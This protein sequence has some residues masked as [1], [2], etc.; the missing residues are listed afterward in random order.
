MEQVYRRLR[1]ERLDERWTRNTVL[2]SLC[3]DLRREERRRAVE[4]LGCG[5]R[6]GEIYGET[7]ASRL[8]LE[9]WIRFNVWYS[10]LPPGL[11]SSDLKN[12]QKR[13]SILMYMIY[14]SSSNLS[15]LPV[16]TREV[17]LKP[18]TRASTR[19]TSVIE[20]FGLENGLT[21]SFS[22]FNT[23]KYKPY[24]HPYQKSEDWKALEELVL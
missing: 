8:S 2:W 13:R 5:L 14:P 22:P 12:V 1:R 18:T 6:N 16:E 9:S 21:Y 17:F 3:Q 20:T 7:N 19:L 24:R 10:F 23:S 11:P 15:C 4:G